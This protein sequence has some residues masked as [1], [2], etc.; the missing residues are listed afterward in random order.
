MTLGT[1]GVNMGT[2][3]MC[4][5]EAPVHFNIK[6]STVKAAENDTQLVLRRWKNTSRY[7]KNSVTEAAAK[8]EKESQTGKFD[9]VQQFVSGKRGREVFI[10][11]DP[12]LGVRFKNWSLRRRFR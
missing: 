9:E 4:T 11:G 2:R 6:E 5:V 8:V 7:F 10:N 1:C 3:F 12:E